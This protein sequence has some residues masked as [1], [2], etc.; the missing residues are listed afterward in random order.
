MAE[1]DFVA[2]PDVFGGWGV[3]DAGAGGRLGGGGGGMGEGLR[4]DALAGDDG[5]CGGLGRMKEWK[6]GGGTY[7]TWCEGG[8]LRR[9]RLWFWWD[10][11]GLVRDGLVGRLCGSGTCCQ[12]R[13]GCLGRPSSSLCPFF[14]RCEGTW[15]SIARSRCWKWLPGGCGGGDGDEVLSRCGESDQSIGT[16]KSDLHGVR[17]GRQKICWKPT[18]RGSRLFCFVS[19]LELQSSPR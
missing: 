6:R 15:S 4:V 7:G 12:G 19:H 1:V 2:D 9:S 14:E 17:R 10:C 5:G 8:L 16:P 18:S 13:R 11:W 3:A